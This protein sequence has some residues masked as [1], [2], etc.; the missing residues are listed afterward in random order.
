MIEQD[1]ELTRL[2]AK[3]ANIKLEQG[4]TRLAGIMQTWRPRDDDGDA[5]RLG[6]K[7]K[8]MLDYIE[9]GDMAGCVVA[10]ASEDVA[11]YE[12]CYPNP[13]AATRLVILRAAAEIGKTMIE[14]E[15]TV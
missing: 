9:K 13:N 10:V 14:T 11:A 5:L 1:M 15:G 3:A 6:V 12:P 7:L 2:A 8:I 4:T